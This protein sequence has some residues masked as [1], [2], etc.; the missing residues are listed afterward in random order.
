ML[1]VKRT[2]ACQET[3]IC[4]CL[5]YIRTD[6]YTYGC[7]QCTCTNIIMSSLLK[8]DNKI[9]ITKIYMK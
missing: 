8:N 6:V 9:I 3:N 7:Y 5:S 2:C 4:T 1:K